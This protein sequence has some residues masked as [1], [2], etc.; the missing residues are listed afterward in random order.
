[1]T[2]IDL[3]IGGDPEKI[4]CAEFSLLPDSDEPYTSLSD[5]VRKLSYD[6]A[7]EISAVQDRIRF[8]QRRTVE[9][10][11]ELGK[12][13]VILKAI[14][15]HGDFGSR[16]GDLGF[17]MRTAQCFMRAAIRVAQNGGVALLA[18]QA[19]NVSAFLEMVTLED[20]DIQNILQLDDLDKMS[21]SQLRNLA[22]N[23]RQD[24]DVLQTELNTADAKVRR[25]QSGYASSDP[26]MPKETVISRAYCLGAQRAVELKLEGLWKNFAQEAGAGTEDAR[27]RLEQQWVAANII[28]A[29]AL[30]TVQRMR[31]A[32]PVDL[33][34]RIMGQHILTPE[35]AERW[36][37]DARLIE[38]VEFSERNGL[39]E[40]E[41]RGRGRPR[42]TQ[43]GVEK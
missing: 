38:D 30:E 28:A 19:K 16:I 24:K 9:D 31:E 35:E 4:K 14:T 13:L 3:G 5:L 42:K 6:G 34:E 33:P 15:D 43:D 23:L 32:S 12:A 11:I 10:A 27:L 40:P 1:M 37:R 8:Y 39:A 41:K 21:A 29:R 36:A 26:E 25:L 7:I 18:K 17:S 22:R 2:D 20:D